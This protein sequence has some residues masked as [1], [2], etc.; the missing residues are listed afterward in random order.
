MR[1]GSTWADGLC[2]NVELRDTKV[3]FFVA[4]LEQGEHELRYR[5]RAEAPGTF[6]APPATGFAMY[7][8]EL[9][10][11]SRTMRLSVKDR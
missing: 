5:L 8:P 3:V 2:A 6:R 10:A 4:L 9:R 11:N 7:A 1:S